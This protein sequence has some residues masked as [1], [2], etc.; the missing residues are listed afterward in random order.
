MPELSMQMNVEHAEPTG[1]GLSETEQA[2]LREHA[3][4]TA[5][6]CAWLPGK[7][8]SKRPR[9][10]YR[11]CAARFSVLERELYNLKSGEPPD[12]VKWLYD[13]VRLLRSQ[14]HDVADSTKPMGKLPQVRTARDESVPRCIVLARS[15]LSAT[16]NRLTE[17]AFSFFIE[18]VEEVEPLRL[19]ELWGMIPALKLALLEIIVEHGRKA[20]DAFRASGAA[21]P[22]FG[23]GSMVTS[24]RSLSESDWKETLEQLSVVH[25]A[26][27]LDP[28]GVYS[29]MDFESREYY[30]QVLEKIAAQSDVGELELAQ[31][32]VTM[33]E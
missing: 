1:Y 7:A 11:R 18:A 25:R 17:P 30:R 9:E 15:L 31:M 16:D 20:L 5:R 28:A 23:I 24:L 33:A 32:A 2:R 21:I 12:D 3:A 27:S 19:A 6:S 29:R 22:S 8:R 13:N 4:Q 10:I 26:L 14:L